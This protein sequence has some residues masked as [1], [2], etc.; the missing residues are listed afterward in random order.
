MLFKWQ[1][2]LINKRGVTRY[3]KKIQALKKKKKFKTFTSYYSH[4]QISS[5]KSVPEMPSLRKTRDE[6][7]H[8][9]KAKRY[10][11]DR[12]LLPPR[13]QGNTQ[14]YQFLNHDVKV[15]NW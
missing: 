2:V 4:E 8:F 3:A 9:Q 15:P 1:K 12:L 5:L 14:T 7:D 10:S 11:L 6:L 13:K